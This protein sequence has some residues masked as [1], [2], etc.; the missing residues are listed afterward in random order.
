[1]IINIR[2]D[3]FVMALAFFALLLIVALLIYKYGAGTDKTQKSPQPDINKAPSYGDY[4]TWKE[5]KKV[6][7]K[8][9]RVTVIDFDS[10]LS[11]RVQ[12]RGG[13]NHADVQPLT[14]ADTAIMKKIYKGQWS[15]KRRAVIVKLDNGQELA[16]SMNGMPHGQ[17]AIRENNFNGHFCIHF[18]NSKTHGS[19][20]EDLAHQMMIWKAANILDQQLQLLP[21]QEIIKVF[22]TAID[23]NEINIVR[24]LIYYEGNLEPL[25]KN[26]ESI[27]NIKINKITQAEGNTFKVDLRVVLKNSNQEFRKSVLVKMVHKKHWLVGS[28]W[29]L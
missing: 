10:R 25:L 9:A 13:S 5:V 1:M 19:N 14:A 8:K 24:K 27:E 26:L 23:Q 21:P 17:G 11:F 28:G 12:R 29:C 16:A 2:K 7:P 22:V 3:R 20:K 4:L 18:R 15:W 6:F